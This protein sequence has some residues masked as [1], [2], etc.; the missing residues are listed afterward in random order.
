LMELDTAAGTERL[1]GRWIEMPIAERE[2]MARRAIECF[3]ARYDMRE[4]AKTV[5]RLF[6]SGEERGR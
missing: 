2:A 1:L 5:A 4:N 3:H 6:A